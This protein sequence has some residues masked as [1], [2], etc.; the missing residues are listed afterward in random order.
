MLLT[1]HSFTCRV[2]IH[3]LQWQTTSFS[4]IK[5]QATIYK[6]CNKLADYKSRHQNSRGPTKHKSNHCLSIGNENVF[7]ALAWP[8]SKTHQ[9][10]WVKTKR[11]RYKNSSVDANLLLR[12]HKR[13]GDWIFTID[14]LVFS[15]TY[16]VWHCVFITVIMHFYNICR[17]QQQNFMPAKCIC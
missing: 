7:L 11:K 2:I 1:E 17:Y 6:L 13:R 15:R 9:C 5:H 3:I 12:F 8:F 14:S 16:L 4:H 10:G